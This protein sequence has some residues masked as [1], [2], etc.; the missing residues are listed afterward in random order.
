[1]REKIIYGT[2][3]RYD[4]SNNLIYYK[5]PDGYELWNEYDE[6]GN[7]IHYKDSDGDE[8]WW[9]YDENNNCIM[10]RCNKI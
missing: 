4:D 2:I 5:S 9:D 7:L 10:F 1:M 8:R 3:V 6:N